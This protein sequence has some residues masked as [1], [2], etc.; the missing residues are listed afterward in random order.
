MTLDQ[1]ALLE[2]KLDAIRLEAGQLG[3]DV[4]AN[5]DSLLRMAYKA[6]RMGMTPDEWKQ[7]FVKQAGMS[8]D[9][10][11]LGGALG[12]QRSFVE[13]TNRKWMLPS[14]SSRDTGQTALDIYL[15]KMT[16]T[17][18]NEA[19]KQE[20]KIAYPTL[21]PMIDQGMTVEG[22]MGAYK[23]KAEDLLERPINFMGKD[24]SMFMH[25][26]SGG[27]RSE[28]VPGVMSLWQA[29]DYVRNLPEWQTTKNAVDDAYDLAID[30]VE[31]FGGLGTPSYFRY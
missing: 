23:T 29:G 8:F 22:F 18:Y 7:E 1:L 24:N 5:R 2:A 28:G 4:V 13:A 14:G 11:R 6:S 16:Q 30:V 10:D 21:A 27:E 20:A 9:P 3:I 15:G 19:L 26:I 25:I 12:T 17:N 31:L